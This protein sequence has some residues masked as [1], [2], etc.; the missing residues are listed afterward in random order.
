MGFLGALS[1]SLGPT[2]QEA[3]S[4]R[5]GEGLRYGAD[6]ACASSAFTANELNEMAAATEG[7]SAKRNSARFLDR[8][9]SAA[10]AGVLET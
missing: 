10:F 5:G 2:K 4:A 9:V 3:L 1:F 6:R 8:Q 7:H